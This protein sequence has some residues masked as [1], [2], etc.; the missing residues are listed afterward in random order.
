MAP[1]LLDPLAIPKYV[2]ELTGPPPVWEP[3]VVKRGGRVVAHEYEIEMVAFSQQ[4]LPPGFPATPVW[5]Y[6][7][8]ARDALTGEQLGYVRSSPGASFEAV[9]GVPASVKWINNVRSPHMFPVDPTL[10]W[11]DPNGFGMPMPPFT[12]YPPGYPEAQSPVPLVT[13]LHGSEV[14]STS[15]GGPDAWFTWNGIH[16]PGYS[17]EKKAKRNEAVFYYPN[18]QPA[19][20]LWYHDH[21]LGVTRINVM[22]GLAGFYLLRDPADPIAPLLPSGKYEMP[23]VIQ[24]R[25]FNADGTMW[26][27]TVGLNPNDHPYWMPEFFGDTIMVN[28]KVWPNLNVDQGQY[29]FRLLDGSNARFYTLSFWVPATGQRLPF[30]QIG[31][32]GGYLRSPAWLTE[33]T[34]APGERADVLVDFSGLPAGTKVILD[35]RAKAPFPHGTPANPQ[36]VG[37]IMQFTVTGA[38]GPAPAGL[39]PILNPA[40]ASFPSLPSPSE[41]R[42]RVLVEVMGAGGPLEILLNGQKWGAPVSE[43]PEL[44]A[45]EEWVVVNPT[46]DTHPIHLHLVQFQLVYRQKVQAAQY[47]ADWMMRNGGMPP[48]DEEPME[49]EVGP[50]LVGNPMPAPPEEQGWK[51]T[52]RMNPGEVTVIRVR[53]A[54]IDGT[55]SYPFDATVGPGYVW[56][57]HILDHE[58]NEMMRPYVV[59]R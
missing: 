45:T 24:D 58:D 52:L 43:M 1:G 17:T 18:G 23:I 36:T 19:T 51:D 37:Q 12:P 26:F 50:Y 16:G 48:Y 22:S 14:Q 44:G 2:N 46:A 47:N 9:R 28:G 15:D 56:H 13:H 10:H 49:L 30:V 55:P 34:F 20:T 7:G 3:T 27:P 33:L 41:T 32:D 54:P 5:G 4:I 59:T 21:A 31:S 57:C 53:F 8:F 38:W 11:A 35:N 40:L 25:T 39:P 6:G 42:T 29:R